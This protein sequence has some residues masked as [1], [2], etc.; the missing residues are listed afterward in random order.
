[1]AFDRAVVFVLKHE[2]GFVDDPDDPGG[3]TNHGVTQRVYDQWRAARGDPP[4]SV[5]VIADDEVWTIYKELYWLPA[6]CG[7]LPAPLDL[8]H[9][10]T[11]VNCGVDAAVRI[12]Q[13]ALGVVV[14]GAVG[15]KTIEVAQA[16][17][18]WRTIGRYVNGRLSR[19]M[20]LAQ[21]RPP[22][23]KF[24]H[25]WLRRVGDLLREV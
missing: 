16:S 4:R 10:D 13:T 20:M 18:R 12:L 24:L 1:M 23:A 7:D 9:F 21:M 6:R 22:M 15:P 14:D 5:A 19:Y 25:G 2:G 11:A 8:V 17:D 3:A